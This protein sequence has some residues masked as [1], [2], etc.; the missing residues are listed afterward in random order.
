MPVI[1]AF[2]KFL[3]MR[4]I[5]FTIPFLVFL[6]TLF[7]QEVLPP[8]LQSKYHMIYADEMK[9]LDMPSKAFETT[10][11]PTGGVRNIAEF[12]RNQGV[13]ISYPGYFGIPYTLISELAEDVTVYVICESSDQTNVYNDLDS[14]G[15]N[16]ANIEFVDAP[17]D[18]HWA[19]DYS[20][21]FIEHGENNELGIVNFPYNRPRPNDDEIPVVFG[22]YLDVDVFGM[23]LEHTGGNYMCDGMGTSAS[24]N[25]VYT[26]NPGLSASEV[27]DLAFDYLGADT[28]HLVQD[29]LDDYIEHIDC[30]G[31]FLDVDK[32]L[33]AS[34]P[35]SDYRYADFE[36]MADYW[37]NETTPYGNNYQVYRTAWMVEDNAYTNSL[38]M[39]D[40]VLIPFNTGSAGDYNAAAAE[41]YEEAMPG[42]EVIGISYNGWYSTDALHC[43]THEVP[44]KEMLRIE[45][46]PT[47]GSVE[48]QEVY[49]FTADVY[50][51]GNAATISSVE[52]YYSVNGGAYSSV[53]MNLVSGDTYSVSISTFNEEETISYYIEAQNSAAKTETHPF[54]GE[55]DPHVFTIQSSTQ[56]INYVENPY[57]KAYPNPT[58]ESLYLITNNL[59]QDEYVCTIYDQQG[60]LVMTINK[61]MY[62][63]EWDLR[64]IDISSLESGLYFVR[65]TSE[66]NT[67]TTKFI[68]L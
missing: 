54:I 51:F 15:V 1:P 14:E 39:N 49:E 10:P 68:K 13:I 23:D 27:D 38:I 5:L 60:K 55:P 20:P 8:E 61:D 35:A 66:G 63:S 56:N 42:Y 12:E 53:P 37:A 41:I 62:S 24:C 11:P 26:E 16:M 4:R 28:Y 44:D 2:F 19:R 57:V 65:A 22:T 6:G 25:L 31:K 48:Y 43:R 52:F 7:A 32:M 29:P 34:V 18:S 67:F 30:W 46:F 3:E 33:V 58:K 17:L 21:W 36:A 50:T 47:L 45:H 9:N 64:Q 59:P 40:K